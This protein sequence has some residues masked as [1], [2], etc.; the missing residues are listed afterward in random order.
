MKAYGGVEVQLQPKLV[1]AL[2]EGEWSDYALAI[3]LGKEQA[4]STHW[5]QSWVGP[6][7]S[8]DILTTV[9]IA[10]SPHWY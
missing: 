9:S 1:M 5:T 4:L 8:H 6:K 10:S 3:F 7:A 2:D